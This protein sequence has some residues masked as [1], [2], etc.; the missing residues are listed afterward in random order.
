MTNL[1]NP[2]TLSNSIT[3]LIPIILV[4]DSGQIFQSGNSFMLVL[5]FFYCFTLISG[6]IPETILGFFPGGPVSG[7]RSLG[8]FVT[9][10]FS[11]LGLLPFHLLTD[12]N[13][14]DTH[15]EIQ[16]MNQL[17]TGSDWDRYLINAN[18][19]ASADPY[20]QYY[21]DCDHWGVTFAGRSESSGL[22][23]VV[24]RPFQRLLTS[25]GQSFEKYEQ[26]LLALRQ[27]GFQIYNRQIYPVL[28]ELE[29]RA[30][31]EQAHSEFRLISAG[32]VGNLFGKVNANILS[33]REKTNRFIATF[34]PDAGLFHPAEWCTKIAN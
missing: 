11:P 34:A 21:A 8:K 27:Q 25:V 18:S 5:L 7:E 20:W 29:F 1:P 4:I 16:E 3:L 15:F 23:Q 30:N 28:L 12:G 6:A 10:S 2:P 14:S 17:A 9:G 31:Q 33:L 19:D 32:L 24:D 22:Q 26:E 13:P